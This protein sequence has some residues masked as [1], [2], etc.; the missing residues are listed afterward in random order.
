MALRISATLLETHRLYRAGLVSES[1]WRLRLQRRLPQTPAMIVGQAFGALLAHPDRAVAV[2]QGYIWP[3]QPTYTFARSLLDT[4]WAR[5]ADREHTIFEALGTCELMTVHSLDAVQCI[6]P[7]TLMAYADQLRGDGSIIETKTVFGAVDLDHY[8]ASM[9]WRVL[10][11]AF[12]PTVLQYEIWPLRLE[13][14]SGHIS[15][16]G[17]LVTC[18]CWSYPE[19]ARD[20]AS[21]V[22]DLCAAAR[23]AGF[24][25]YLKVPLTEEQHAESA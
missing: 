20:V 18:R 24:L 5:C 1:N 23:R 4:A 6:E 17:D 16:A 7:V 10:W 15:A 8:L 14:D 2:P 21:L 12:Q 11:L 13:A 25:R 19:L 22:D 9:Q 3:D